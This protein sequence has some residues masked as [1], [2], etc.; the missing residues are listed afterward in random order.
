MRSKICGRRLK[1]P[2]LDI[3]PERP[4]ANGRSTNVLNRDRLDGAV[5]RG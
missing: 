5:T 3:V 1:R 2:Y 4:Y